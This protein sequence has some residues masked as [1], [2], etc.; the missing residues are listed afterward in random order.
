MSSKPQV[1]QTLSWV[2]KHGFKPVPLHPE[3]KAA[4]S[5]EYTD[6]NYRPPNDDFW[7]SRDYGIGVATGPL[8]SGPV[9]VDLDCPEAVAMAA[10]F[11]PPTQAIFGRASKPRSHYL[12]VV[13]SATCAKIAFQDAK[14]DAKANAETLVELRGDGGHQTVFPG[15]I[16]QDTKEP[17]EW[18]EVPFPEIPRVSE[19]DLLKAVRFLAIACLLCRHAWLPGQRNEA[20]KHIAGMGYMLGW[21]EEETLN[22]VAGCCEFWGDKDKT[23]AM[24]VRNTYKKAANGAKVTG[25]RSLSKLLGNDAVVARILQWVGP[26][27]SSVV[28]EYNEIFAVVNHGGKFRIAHTD[29]PP[30]T[31]PVFSSKDDFLLLWGND[32]T[33]IEDKPVSKAKVWLGSTRRRQCSNIDF[34]PGVEDTGNT[35]NL[36]TGW[37]VKPLPD[38]SKCQAWLELLRDHITGKHEQSAE[39]LLHWFAN[40]VREPMKKSLTAPV[41]IGKQGAGKSLLVNYFGRILG[42]AFVTVTNADHLYGRFN[43]HTTTCLLMHSEEALF[44]GEKKHR[45]VIKSLITDET[46]MFEAKGLDAKPV[47]NLLRLIMTSNED[48]AAPAEAGDRRFSVFDLQ[49]RKISPELVK[50]VV[51]EMNGDGPAALLDYLMTMSYDASIARTNLKNSALENMKAVGYSPIEEWWY[52]TLQGGQL[53]PDFLAWCQKPD[54]EDWPQVI[55][56][57]TLYRW[58]VESMKGQGVRNLPSPVTFYHQLAKMVGQKLRKERRIYTSPGATDGLPQ[59]VA[60][61]PERQNSVLNLPNLAKCRRAFEAYTGGQGIEWSG[62]EPDHEKPIYERF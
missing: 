28:A 54:K 39:W 36:W 7:K 8:H 44:G 48:H 13:D 34:L 50:R 19:A 59:W 40:I 25:S 5:R 43:A 53:L 56:S 42:S 21:T 6:P 52:E 3:S 58:A 18:S 11:L 14:P 62:S 55:G 33:V 20:A 30:G 51:A 46:R 10:R 29:V 9:D 41:I 47:N 12:Y 24:V 38:H 27:P 37:A 57:V 4:L 2:R 45:G 22:I 26:G 35:L 23:R 49:K 31:A 61:L 17:I 32:Y 60:I 1:L 15:S 16:H